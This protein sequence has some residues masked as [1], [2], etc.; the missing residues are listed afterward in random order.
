MTTNTDRAKAWYETLNPEM[1]ADNIEWKL[2]DGFPAD[3]TFHGR[4]EIFGVW[5]PKLAAQFSDWHASPS[6]FIDAGDAVVV[7]GQYSGVAK[8][9]GKTF[10]APFTHIWWFNEDGQI[11]RMNHS[12][13]TLT[14]HNAITADAA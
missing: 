12:A 1:L 14:L 11:V 5:W 2:A 7:T 6:E 4:E 3:G 9:T 10:E 13:N 8:A